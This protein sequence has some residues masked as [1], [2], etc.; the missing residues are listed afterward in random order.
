MMEAKSEAALRSISEVAHY[1]D[2]EPHVLRFW[3]S[4]IDHI[5]PLKHTG[6]RRFYRPD[7]V[8]LLAGIRYLLYERG[9]TIKGVQKILQ[10]N[11][12]PYVREIGQTKSVGTPA[13]GKATAD[14]GTNIASAQKRTLHEAREK[15]SEAHDLLRANFTDD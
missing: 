3:E 15:L 2:V 7:D 12:A 4:R 10:D 1:L 11:G 5:Q 13:G 9:L 14:A 8:S 6:R